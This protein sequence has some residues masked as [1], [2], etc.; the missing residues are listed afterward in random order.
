VTTRSVPTLRINDS[1]PVSKKLAISHTKDIFKRVEDF[2]NE[3]YL[4]DSEDDDAIDSVI[5]NKKTTIIMVGQ[6]LNLESFIM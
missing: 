5:K 6:G 4:K 2:E 1:I 3:N